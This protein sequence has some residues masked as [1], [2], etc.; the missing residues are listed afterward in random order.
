MIIIIV[1]IIVLFFSITLKLQTVL[2]NYCLNIVQ[3]AKKKTWIF[4]TLTPPNRETLF[5]GTRGTVGA[6]VVARPLM[7]SDLQQADEAGERGQ[8]TGISQ[9][10][11][12]GADE[13]LWPRVDWAG[14]THAHG[15]GRRERL[16]A[17]RPRR[18]NAGS[19]FVGASVLIAAASCLSKK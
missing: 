5:A 4:Q 16:S 2:L 7:R 17:S 6:P 8:S 19:R 12:S 18:S 10:D 1:I 3:I 13:K 14:H 9:P 15:P 11:E